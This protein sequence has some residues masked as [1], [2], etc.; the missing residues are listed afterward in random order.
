LD[1]LM[2]AFPPEALKLEEETKIPTKI[3]GS[4]NLINRLKIILTRAKDVFSKKVR[5]EPAKVTPLDIRVEREKW[6]IKANRFPPRELGL[7]RDRELERQCKS[8]LEL[9]CI[10]WSRASHY[11]FAF[12]VPKPNGEW[13]F[14][15][16]FKGLNRATINVE[17]WP[18]PYIGV[19]L[20][21]IGAKRPILFGVMDFTSGFFQAPIGED[22]CHL[23]AFITRQG[24]FE[25]VRVPMGITAA[26]SYFQRVISTQVLAGLCGI[27]CEVYI[28]DVIVY[29]DSEES[30]LEAVKAV[31]QRFQEFGI[32]VN[33]DKCSFG[34][35]EIEYVGHTISKDGV[36][37]KRSKL[38][39][40]VNFPKPSNH[41]EL[42]SFIGLVNYFREHIKNASLILQ[43]LE[44]EVTP[45][46]PKAL[47]VW[48]SLLEESF[49]T[50]KKAVDE[51][52]KLYFVNEESKVILETDASEVGIGA[53]L[54]QEEGEEEHPIAFLS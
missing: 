47:V 24:L 50:V 49:E 7:I 16:N 37:F 35:P 25:W 15:L 32:T 20:R 6:E 9:G 54:Y 48:N 28:D 23:T 11:S 18:I 40:V 13:R 51:C 30:F 3:Y 42:K 19:L 38:D 26:P 31:L 10:R 39:S 1:V 21:R 4:E 46:H 22:S 34:L 52:P 12:L 5:K 2:E 17:R 36:S 33:P 44:I 8:L 43:P 41:K 14:V 45:Y 27:I 29:G 53:Y